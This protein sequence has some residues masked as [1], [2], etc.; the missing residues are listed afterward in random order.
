M[1]LE[2]K[3]EKNDIVTVKL[4]TGEELVG[5]AVKL[6]A[7]S[8]VLELAKPFVLGMQQNQQG[9][10]G[11]GFGPFMFGISDEG[12]VVIENGTY[13]VVARARDE[14]RTAYTKSTT[15]L[16]VPPAGAVIV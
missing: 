15:G 4:V 8:G 10:I 1:L 5:K 14:I 16:E 7:D 11:L 6:P 12:T 2:K 9:A 3:L 13:I